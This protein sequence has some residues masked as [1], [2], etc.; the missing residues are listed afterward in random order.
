VTQRLIEPMVRMWVR[1]ALRTGCL[2]ETHGQNTLF[3]FSADGSTSVAYRDSAVYVDAP[4]RPGRTL[5]PTNVIPRDVP[6]PAEEV[7]SLTYD[8][9]MGHHA[10]SYVAGLVQDGYGVA[11]RELHDVARAAFAD[12]SGGALRM[13][14]ST[15]YYDDRLYDD[16][17][18]KLV[19]TGRPPL[20]R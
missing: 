17:D 15:F 20:W 14:S 16:G 8:S 11:P 3:R 4:L 1:A 19:D 7:R 5:P 9:F 18:W 13:P 2:L 10:L 12:E 6:M